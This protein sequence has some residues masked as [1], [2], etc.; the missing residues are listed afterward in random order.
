VR[1]DG[2][3]WLQMMLALPESKTQRL[4]RVG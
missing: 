2:H 3:G 4:S 1:A